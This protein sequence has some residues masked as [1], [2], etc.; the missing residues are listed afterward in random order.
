GRLSSC[1]RKWPVKA[2]L[3]EALPLLWKTVAEL[4]STG[5]GNVERDHE[6]F[7]RECSWDAFKRNHRTKFEWAGDMSVLPCGILET[8][9]H[10]RRASVRYRKHQNRWL[11]SGLSR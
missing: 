2:Q 6:R 10:F 11:R 8:E 5:R 9:R 3:R 7:L 1:A 4:R